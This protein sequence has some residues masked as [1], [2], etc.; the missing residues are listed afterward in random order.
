MIGTAPVSS[1]D[2]PPDDELIR[3][4]PVVVPTASDW[5]PKFPFP[6]DQTR[7]EVTEADINAQREMCQWYTAQYETLRNQIDRVQFNRITPNGPGVISGSGSDWDYSIG[8]IQQQV[9]IVTANIDQSVAFLAPRVQALTQSRNHVGD[10]H[11]PLYEG[12]SF[13]LLWQHLANVGAGIRA[14]QPAWFTGPSVQR[15]K[16]WGS[17]IGRSHVCD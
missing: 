2:P 7:A 4:L 6:Y 1:A 14:H 5:Q 8:D 12:E 11:F 3:P 13:Y 15:V 17:S 10:I 16:R 9:D